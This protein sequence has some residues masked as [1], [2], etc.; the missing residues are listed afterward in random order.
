MGRREES[1]GDEETD[2]TNKIIST[3]EEFIRREEKASI[4]RAT[5]LYHFYV[6]LSLTIRIN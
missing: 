1:R 6:V 4:F 2:S 3:L 5:S